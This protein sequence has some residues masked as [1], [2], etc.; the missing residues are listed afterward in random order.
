ME[1]LT[2]A[3]SAREWRRELR[4]AATGPLIVTEWAGYETVHSHFPAREP[5][6]PWLGH[7]HE[8]SSYYHGDESKAIDAMTAFISLYGHDWDVDGMIDKADVTASH[9]ALEQL[10][11]TE[12]AY[13]VAAFIQAWLYFGFLEAVIARPISSAYMTRTDK[14]GATHLYSRM[15][16]VLLE[17]WMRRLS[18]MAQDVAEESLE[19]AM[20]CSFRASS[21]LAEIIKDLSNCSDSQAFFKVKSLLLSVEP[22]M[23]ALHEA[24]ATFVRVNLPSGTRSFNLSGS[25]LPKTY[26]ESLIRKG[27]CRFIVANAEKALTAAFMRFL[28][29]A[30]FVGTTSGHEHC[31]A[32]ACY[33]N[34]IDT[35]NYAPQHWVN[36]CQCDFIKPDLAAVLHILDRGQIPVVRLSDHGLSLDL[37]ALDPDEKADYAAFSHVWADGLGSTTDAG[38]PTCQVQRLHKLAKKRTGEGYFWIDALCVPKQQ[39][40]RTE[41]IKLMMQTYENATGVI[42]LDR[43]LRSLSMGNSD[44]EVGWSLVASSWFGRLWTY[45][46]GF[47]ARWVDMDVSDGMIDLDALVQRLYR[48]YFERPEGNPFPSILSIEL[49]AM[50]QK[51]RP[52]DS[53]HPRR[54]LSRRL[55]DLFN[56]MTRRLTSRPTDQFL[57]IGLF[58]GLDLNC[59]GDVSFTWA[60]STWI[61]TGGDQWLHYNDEEASITENGLIVTLRVLVLQERVETNFSRVVLQTMEP[62]FYELSRGENSTETSPKLSEFNVLIARYA[63]GEDPEDVLYD[64]RSVLQEAGLGLKDEILEDE[65]VPL[66]HDFTTGYD[67]R[68]IVDMRELEQDTS[69]K[70]EASWTQLKCCF[71]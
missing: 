43:G 35:A 52:L 5:Q 2:Y 8:S 71:K 36:G 68:E 12:A 6:F 59:N 64:T 58:L 27:W 18:S 1:H 63:V 28:D 55:V 51:A 39:P 56:A 26:S 49:L 4:E 61:S 24:V 22:A 62:H 48:R 42:L 32:H 25:P 20:Q 19:M 29:T 37:G 30:G 46:E 44:L 31:V 50:L 21:A 57:V 23:S 66:S 13:Q 41:A 60:P 67:I 17:S 9:P 33:R 7:D 69:P 38:L 15:L 14:G 34:N 16:P 45:Q 40:Q 54:P 53:Q 47:V 65:T 10:D 70:I 3:P 11:A